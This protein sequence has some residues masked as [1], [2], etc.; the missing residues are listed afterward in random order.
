MAKGIVKFDVDYALALCSRDGEDC[1]Y[2]MTARGPRGHYLTV[3]VDSD[4]GGFVGTMVEDDGPYASEREADTAGLDAAGTWM[5][6]N[7]VKY[8]QADYRAHIRR[9]KGGR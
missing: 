7:D 6:D 9:I 2:W 4:T 1:V 5:F 8:A 3:V